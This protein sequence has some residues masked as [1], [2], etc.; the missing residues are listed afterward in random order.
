MKNGGNQFTTIPTFSDDETKEV[1]KYTTLYTDAG[2]FEILKSLDEVLKEISECKTSGELFRFKKLDEFS[3]V[4]E[5]YGE[6]VLDISN[7]KVLGYREHTIIFDKV[8][9]QERENAGLSIKK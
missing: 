5:H 4:V 1:G 7:T 3:Q 9:Q 2:N 8:K 6:L